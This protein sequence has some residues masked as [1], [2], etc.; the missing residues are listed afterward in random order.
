MFILKMVVILL[1]VSTILSCKTVTFA[2]HHQKKLKSDI[3][4]KI[5]L[6]VVLVSEYR[7]LTAPDTN[8]KVT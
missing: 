5:N 4:T 6:L 3:C 8:C 2:A 7:E 1:K